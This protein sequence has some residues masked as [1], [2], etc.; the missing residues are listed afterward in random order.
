MTGHGTTP[1]SEALDA[2]GLLPSDGAIRWRSHL[3]VWLRRLWAW[4]WPSA[5][6]LFLGGL[7]LVVRPAGR[8]NPGFAVAIVILAGAG[9]AAATLILPRT[10]PTGGFDRVCW[11]VGDLAVL[12]GDGVSDGSGGRSAFA[13]VN[14][15]A[16]GGL[17]IMTENRS[18]RLR[19]FG[20]VLTVH[21]SPRGRVCSVECRTDQTSQQLQAFGRLRLARRRT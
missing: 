9:A 20:V 15:P 11:I 1:L 4:L 10:R 14:L 17:A 5:F 21:A 6:I 3:H 13:I 19:E 7:F 16:D 2:T 18:I 12:F 8:S